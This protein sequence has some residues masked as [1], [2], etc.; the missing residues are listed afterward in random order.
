MVNRYEFAPWLVHICAAADIGVCL[1]LLCD[2][3][4]IDGFAAATRRLL[5]LEPIDDLTASSKRG[6]A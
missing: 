6:P 2:Y 5:P 3:L 1:W 4:G